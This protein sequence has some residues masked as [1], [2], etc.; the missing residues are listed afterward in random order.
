MWSYLTIV[1][2]LLVGWL[3]GMLTFKR[4]EH[5][6]RACG[7]RL[8]CAACVQRHVFANKRRRVRR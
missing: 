6:C 8:T 3:A 7:T 1:V 5:W 4:S 2:A